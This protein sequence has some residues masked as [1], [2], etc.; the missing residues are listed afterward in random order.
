MIC[1]LP[2]SVVAKHCE[3]YCGDISYSYQ[4]EVP[5][6]SKKGVSTPNCFDVC[7]KL[8]IELK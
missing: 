5:F 4:M 3:F 2:Y 7:L 1:R 8:K 6:L